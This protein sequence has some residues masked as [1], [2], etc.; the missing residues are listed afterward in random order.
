MHIPADVPLEQQ[1][2]Y[3]RNMAALTRH[4]Q[5][6]LIFTADQKLEHMHEDFYDNNIPADCI[7]PHHLFKIALESPISAM[8]AHLGFIAQ[9]GHLYPTIPYL[10]KLNGKTHLIEKTLQEDPISS[11]LWSVEDVTLLKKSSNINIVGIGYTL[12]LGSKF[13]H[14]MLKEAAQIIFHAHRK[15]L[16]AMLWVYPRGKAVINETAPELLAGAAGVANTLGADIVKIKTPD[17]AHGNVIEQLTMI[18]KAAGT[19]QV[20]CA[21]GPKIDHETFLK[22]SFELFQSPIA[23][24]AIGRNIFQQKLPD[25]LATM[26]SLARIPAKE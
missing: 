6:I 26:Q 5:S 17:P 10:I 21:G 12:Y 13:E 15:G 2:I 7:D 14:Q 25:A 1:E 9:Y 24:L 3:R 23:G 20:V 16:P 22:R 11:Q 8:A 19:T 18:C 4:N